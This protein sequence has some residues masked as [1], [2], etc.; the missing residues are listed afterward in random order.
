MKE[1]STIQEQYWIQGEAPDGI[2]YDGIGFDPVTTLDTAL[3]MFKAIREQ[4]PNDKFRL[5]L[6]T[7]ELINT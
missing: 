3:S 4:Y 6:K 5:V 7:T 2:F 1:P